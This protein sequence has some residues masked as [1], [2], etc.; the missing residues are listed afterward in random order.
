MYGG[1]IR[2]LII[3][4]DILFVDVIYVF[5]RIGRLG[6]RGVLERI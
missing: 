3:V 1:R 4:V 6:W 5:S 2:Y